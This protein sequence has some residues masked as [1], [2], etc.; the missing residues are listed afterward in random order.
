M[1]GTDKHLKQQQAKLHHVADR[2]TPVTIAAK[3]ATRACRQLSHRT[4]QTSMTSARD[5]L[6]SL[7]KR[8]AIAL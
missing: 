4:T 1:A 3:E 2:E 6:A 5:V 7:S 8:V